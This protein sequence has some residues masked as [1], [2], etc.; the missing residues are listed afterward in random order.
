MGGNARDVRAA[1]RLNVI[2]DTVKL[3][4]SR[5]NLWEKIKKLG[6]R[7]EVEACDCADDSEATR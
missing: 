7:N 4:I 5:K 2:C 1:A 6:I 3:G